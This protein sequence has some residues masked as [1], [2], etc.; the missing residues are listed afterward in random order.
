MSYSRGVQTLADHIGVDPA[1]VARALRVASHAHAAIRASHFSHMTDEQFRR[2]MGSDR[3]AVAVVA[4]LAMRFAGRIEDALLL[5]DV[6]HASEGIKA[7][8]LVIREGVGTLPE[9]HGHPHV[10]QA[11]RILQAADL[12]PIVTDGTHELRPGFQVMP[13]CDDFPGWIFIAPDPECDDRQGFAGGRLGYLAVLRF[14]GWGV[15]TEPMP[16][17]LW[18]AVHPDY[19]NNPFPS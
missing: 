10:Q 14:A 12:P 4:N 5:M 18:A 2:L 7:P 15:I 11:I 13:G 17:G 9:Y 16:Q 1:H 6:Y 3:H 19:R 8:R